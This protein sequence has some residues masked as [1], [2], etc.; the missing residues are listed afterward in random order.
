MT[1]FPRWKIWTIYIVCLGALLLSIPNFIPADK[2]KGLPSFIP[3]RQVSLGLDLQGGMHLMLKVDLDTVVQDRLASVAETLRGDLRKAN[4]AYTS[5]NPEANR[6]VVG[7]RA[8][9]DRAAAITAIRTADEEVD[10]VAEGDNLIVTMRPQALQLRR[11]AAVQ[12]SIEIVRRRVDETGTKETSIQ[13]QGADRIVVQLPGVNDRE[14]IKNLLNTTAKLTFRMVD[15]MVSAEEAKRQRP[16]AGADFLHPDEKDERAAGIVY[17]VRK[18]VLVSGDNLVDAQPSFQDGQAVVSF[19]FD[20]LGGK[21]FADA[22]T[23]NVGR[24][25]AVVLDNKV[26]SAPNI[27]E[28]ITGGRGIISGS[29]TTQS[30]NDLAVLLRAGALPA[31]MIIVEERTVGPDLGADAIRAGIYSILVGLSLVVAYMIAAYGR[32]G[33]YAVV[34]LVFNLIIT[35]AVL[36]LLQ[37]T[38]TLPGMAGLLI[39]VGLSVDAN[40]LINER[41]REETIAGRS[42]I[43]AISAGFDRAY[44]TIFDANVTALIKMFLLYFFGSGPVKGFAVTTGIGILTSMFTAT[45]IV[46][47]LVANWYHRRRPTKLSV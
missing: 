27:R 17:V 26:I 9:V 42:A 34:A 44:S 36:S 16:P 10:A 39:A 23:E 18:R 37:A 8:E 35:L 28:P 3:T 41:I 38:L 1:Q 33:V 13:Q 29:F 15:G 40:I 4:I 30:A 31:P 45:V 24:P 6:I 25:F 11:Q 32:F 20:S 5:I 7:V 14:Q 21:R 12:Q 43:S 22:T 46:R 19:R 47:Y 2:L